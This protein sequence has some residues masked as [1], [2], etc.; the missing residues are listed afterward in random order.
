M[1]GK[2]LAYLV[3]HAVNGKTCCQ[4]KDADGKFCL[5]TRLFPRGILIS[6]STN[7]IP[8]FKEITTS[9]KIVNLMKDLKYEHQTTFPLRG[10]DKL[11][12]RDRYGKPNIYSK[13]YS[14]YQFCFIKFSKKPH[15]GVKEKIITHSNDLLGLKL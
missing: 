7:K 4:A 5:G 2:I 6:R 15:F 9:E 13:N 3:V 10:R 1:P 12:F 14:H 11:N 8:F